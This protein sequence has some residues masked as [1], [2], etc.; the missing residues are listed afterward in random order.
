MFYQ[1]LHISIAVL[2]CPYNDHTRVESGSDDPDNLGHFLVGQVGLIHKL[3]K[4]SGCDPDI[5]CSLENSV[6]INSKV[7]MNE[8][9]L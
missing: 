7:Q 3:A 2:L 6:G 1:V 8:C 9:Q 5:T 4:L